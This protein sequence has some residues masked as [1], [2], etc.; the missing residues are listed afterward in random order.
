MALI[1][2]TR[3]G[4]YEITAPLGAG[5]MGEVYRATDSQLKRSVAIKVLPASVAGDADRLARF[6]REAEVLAALNH[7]NIAAIYGLEKT[8]STGPEQTDLTALVMELVDGEDL[9]AHIARGPIALADALPIA[10]QVADALEA[11]HEQGIVHRDLKPANIKVRA[12]GTV[13]V[14]DFGLAKAMDPAGTSGGDAMNSPTLTA[15]ATQMGMILGTAAYMAPEQAKGKAVDKRADIWAF[16]VVLYEMLTGRRA[17]EGEDISTTLAAVLMKDPEWAA[18]PKHL[19]PGLRTLIQ[20]CLERDP[21]ARLRDIGEARLLL[22]SPDAMSAGPAVATS[23][24]PSARTSRLPWLVAA[25][26]VLAA[27]VFAAL[28]MARPAAPVAG[29]R[30]EASLAPPPGHAVGSAFALSPDGRRLVM[31]AVSADTGATSLWLRDLASGAPA[32]L[33][34]TDGGTLPFWSPTGA[35]VAFFAEGKLKK[36]DL[37]GSPPQVI[38]D[39]PSPRGGAWGPNG[40]IVFAGS[41]RTGLEK[42]DAGGGKPAP[43]TTLDQKRHEKSHRW[44]VFLPDGTHLLFLAQTGEA[45]SKDDAS[46]IEAL[47]LDTGAR[48]RILAAN[49]SPLYSADGFLLF[50]REGA[51]RAQAFDPERL[52]ASGAVFSV[53]PGVAFDSNEYAQASVSASGTLV[54]STADTTNRT[55]LLLVDRTGRVT[56]TIAESVLVEGGIALSHDGTRLAAAITAEG[57]RDTDI[58]IYD[59]VRGTSG[60]LTFDEGGDRYPV[61]SADDKQLIYT[62]DRQND[63]IAFRRS[64]NG[65]GQPEQVA[66]NASGLWSWSWSRDG[67]WLVVGASADATAFD[68]LRYDLQ[69][70]KT[71]PL[72]QAPSNDEAGSISPDDRWLAYSSDATGRPEIYVRSLGG[73]AGQWQISNQGG[74]RPSWRADGRELYYLT[75]QGQVMAVEVQTGAAFQSTTPRELFRANFRAAS[76]DYTEFSPMP[77]GQ[78]FV[79]DAMKERTTTLLTLVT[80][81]TSAASPA[82]RGSR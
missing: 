38:C 48:T 82:P 40:T 34:G 31:E 8:A 18:L 15:R 21:K 71:S 55:N 13:K 49:S 19:P 26:G 56:K 33:S 43:L 65:Q 20:R 44:P 41:F 42:V 63:G 58:W 77:G 3:L 68:L 62:N 75:P 74:T 14:L 30:I 16:G 6:Q 51:L 81:W 11:A 45:T 22:S 39:A 23:T 66:S 4:P 29:E 79:I 50:W 5:G 60:K 70:R 1:P 7:P 61:W 52:A 53:A 76:R 72:V 69:D 32:K 46:T 25:F 36:T 59:L 80:N 47:A 35:E 54:Y 9:S 78:H 57:A 10:K 37:Q 27:L 64:V 17:F 67:R 2:G 73:D 28:W 24:V 12:D